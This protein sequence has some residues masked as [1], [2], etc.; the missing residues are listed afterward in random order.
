MAQIKALVLW[1]IYL[2]FG[3]LGTGIVIY[4]HELGHYIAAKLCHVSVEILSFGFGRPVFSHMGKNTEF[5]ISLIPFG[6][7]CRLGGSEDLSVA[8]T[9]NEKKIHY[10]EEGSLFAINP[11]K[12]LFIYFA[13][14][15]MNVIL[16][17]VL[18][19]I[20]ALIPVE[21]VSNRAVITP[22]TEY[23]SL[24][25]VSVTQDSVHKGDTVLEADGRTVADFED[26]S[27]YLS[28][29]DGEDVV[30]KVLRNGEEKE[31]TITP[32]LVNDN[33]TYGLTN[34]IEP[35]IGRSENENIAVGDRI[36][37]CNGKTIEYD[38]DL[39]EIES[40]E[41]VLTLLRDDGTEYTVTLTSSSFP[42]AFKSDIR[43]SRD[44]SNPFSSAWTRTTTFLRRTALAI[45]KL[46]TLQL[47]AALEEI[48]GPVSSAANMGKISVLAFR[49]SSSS[50]I[51][52]VFYLLAIVSISIAVGNMI[53]IPTFD[54]GQ[55]L[56]C[57]AEII[58]R[59]PLRPRAYLILHI[60]GLV[61]AWGIVIMMNAFSFF[62]SLF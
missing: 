26:L 17:F 46:M 13:G 57:L 14:P 55:M 41:Y 35:V 6:G 24:F 18:F 2:I 31:I 9:N 27:T 44:S 42:F 39:L 38:K 19:F 40:D 10:A 21:R 60:T 20:V 58:H 33:W 29:C 37:E 12:K 1:L 36:I 54:G 52:T 16:A 7:Y 50:G 22:I 53:P 5:R 61:L 4:I 28:S 30:L 45:T 59:R 8:L 32:V 25:S 15:M 3:L 48:S 43:I 51:R 47:S 11:L 34:L 56:I 62:S 23:Q 49:T